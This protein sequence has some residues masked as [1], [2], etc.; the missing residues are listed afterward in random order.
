[1]PNKSG[2]TA[3]P[4]FAL[5]NLSPF[6]IGLSGTIGALVAYGLSQA[7]VQARSVL[8]LIIVALFIALGLNPIVELLMRRKL[9]RSIAVLIVFAA[10]LALMALAVFAIVPVFSRQLTTLF[11]AAPNI[12][13]SL[14]THPEIAALDERFQ[15]ITK[16]R[17][18]LTSGNLIR[19]LFGG[20][21]GAGKVVI[22]AVFSGFT[23]LI[24]TLYFLATMP[25][26]KK[27][28]YRLAPASRRERVTY[29]ADQMFSRIGAYLSGMFMVVTTAGVT[30]FIFLW[31]I[32]LHE[33]ALALAV[34]VAI[35]DFIPMIGA[36][37]A[38]VIVCTVAFVDS[39][40]AGI[41]AVIFYVCYQQFENY[42]VQPRVMKKSVDVP[43]AVTVIAALLGGTLL[44]VV[45]AL[46]AVPTAAALLLLMRE[47]VQPRLDAS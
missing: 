34:V 24:L 35:M 5:Q 42:V 32:G 47:V 36:T 18:Y 30:S 38:A 15:I 37:I 7:V 6:R 8:I 10:V 23:L 46:L 41:A 26:I 9:K 28:I 43:G 29:L 44:G 39:P 13:S 11:Y 21:L 27:A 20:V 17:E 33:Y 2:P 25:T 45:G 16:A 4:R 19:Q 12:L 31:I 14:L 40:T 22:G 1:M 3:H